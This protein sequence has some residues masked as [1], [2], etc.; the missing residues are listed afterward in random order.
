[1]YIPCTY[2]V[3]SPGDDLEF[4]ISLASTFGVL[5]YWYVL[6]HCAY[7]VLALEPGLHAYHTSFLSNGFMASQ[8]EH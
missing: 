2:L 1:M 8:K 5:D 3:C 4:P 6:L 7:E